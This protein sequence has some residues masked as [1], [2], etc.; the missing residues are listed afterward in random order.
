[1][2]FKK[3][4]YK[5]QCG[6]YQGERGWEREQRVGEGAQGEGCH[7]CGDGGRPDLGAEHTMQCTD[8]VL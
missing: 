1:M 7:I 4:Q 2:I 5:E 8:G 6:D 3:P